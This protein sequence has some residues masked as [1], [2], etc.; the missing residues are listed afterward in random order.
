MDTQEYF[1][2]SAWVS[3]PWQTRNI[4]CHTVQFSKEKMEM[5]MVS[6]HSINDGRKGYHLLDVLECL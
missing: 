2:G 1:S 4:L 5:F 3:N 6:P